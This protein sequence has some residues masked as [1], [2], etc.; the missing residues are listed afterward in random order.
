[1][2]EDILPK[3]VPHTVAF[4]KEELEHHYTFIWYVFC[5]KKVKAWV[6]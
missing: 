6:L 4:V 1:V 3:A 2:N 5:C